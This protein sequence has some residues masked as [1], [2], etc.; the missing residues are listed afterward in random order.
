[1][2]LRKSPSGSLRERRTAS[3]AGLPGVPGRVLC[4]VL[5]I[6]APGRGGGGGGALGRTELIARWAGDPGWG[7]AA[8]HR[9]C[10]VEPAGG[11]WGGSREGGGGGGRRRRSHRLRPRLPPPPTTQGRAGPR[12]PHLLKVWT[13]RLEPERLASRPRR[14][15]ARGRKARPAAGCPRGARLGSLLALHSFINVS[16]LGR[17]SVGQA[18]SQALGHEGPSPRPRRTRLLSSRSVSGGGGTYTEA[19]G[20]LGQYAKGLEEDSLAR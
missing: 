6:A 19:G 5:P 13:G 1:M 17:P 8:G 11:S 18:L 20:H 12:P 14:S 4:T 10:T 15:R 2:A 16:V 9:G 3:R 7:R